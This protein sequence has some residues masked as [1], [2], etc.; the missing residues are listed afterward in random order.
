MKKN[1]ILLKN[2]IAIISIFGLSLICFVSCD[3][4]SVDSFIDGF[5]QG[6]YGHN[7]NKSSNTNDYTYIGEA[8]SESDCSEMCI[9]NNYMQYRYFI[10]LNKC[11][12]K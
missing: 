1:V 3:A 6:Y 12:C 5:N 11:Q 4:G 2:F 7:Y 8:Y 9:K 10:N